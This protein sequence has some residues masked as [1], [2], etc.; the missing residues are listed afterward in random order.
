[1]RKAIITIQTNDDVTL[2]K[3]VNHLSFEKG[4]EVLEAKVDNKKYVFDEK[5]KHLRYFLREDFGEIKK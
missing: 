1:M 3:V 5:D 4:V 2:Y